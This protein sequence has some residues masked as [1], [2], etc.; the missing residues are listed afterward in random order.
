MYQRNVW[1]LCHIWD[2]QSTAYSATNSISIKYLKSSSQIMATIT[3]HSDTS[4][5]GLHNTQENVRM[6]AM[7]HGSSHGWDI[8]HSIIVTMLTMMSPGQSVDTNNIAPGESPDGSD[9]CNKRVVSCQM[10]WTLWLRP[11]LVR[12]VLLPLTVF[13]TAWYQSCHVTGVQY[14]GELPTVYSN[15]APSYIMTIK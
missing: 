3:P 1:Q 6:L 14:D 15:S 9:T 12:G 7:W 4:L 2:D 8:W 13:I 10:L 11:C 5:S